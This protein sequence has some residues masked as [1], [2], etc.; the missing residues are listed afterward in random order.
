MQ[1]NRPQLPTNNLPPSNIDSIKRVALP[2]A[3]TMG[4]NLLTST[5]QVLE[6]LKATGQVLVS[7]EKANERLDI[8]KACDLYIADAGR[9]SKCGCAMFV[10]TKLE[11]MTCPVGKW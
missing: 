6:H 1:T 7:E 9:C 10:K 2:D 3:K 5:K 4:V 8:C 11:A